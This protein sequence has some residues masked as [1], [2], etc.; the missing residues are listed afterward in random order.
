M[1]V[2][3]FG[4][5]FSISAAVALL[6]ACGGS[7]PPVGAASAISQTFA[8]ATHVDRG[9]SWMLP[10]AKNEDLVYDSC[11]GPDVYVYAYPTGKLVGTLTGFQAPEGLCTDK[12]GDVF[13]ADVYAQDIVEYAHGGD[14]PTATLDDSGNYPNGCA[15][16]QRTGNLAV[17]GGLLS[18]ANVA[19]YPGASGTP[20]V[21]ADPYDTSLFWC[22]Y[23]SASNLFI[24]PWDQFYGGTIVELPAG[25]GNLKRIS[26]NQKLN[27]GGAI[28]WDGAHVVLGNPLEQSHGPSTLYQLAISGS[29]ATVIKT[30][31]LYYNKGA[32]KNPRIGNQFWIFGRK[33]LDADNFKIATW[34][35]PAGG[36]P[37]NGFRGNGAMGLAVSVAPSR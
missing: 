21:Y 33:V 20:T 5:A 12:N 17:A 37:T 4:L 25:G 1:K 26:V 24:N 16:D 9:R 10:E 7:Q 3:K 23:D 18:N 30:I 28:Q 36:Y 35:Y 32:D 29:S 13:V 2:R 22:T 11:C 8:N 27:P 31:T 14:A 19:I 6:A 15:V 34:H